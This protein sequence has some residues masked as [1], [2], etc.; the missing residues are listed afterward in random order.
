MQKLILCFALPLAVASLASAQ[1]VLYQLEGGDVQAQFGQA[2]ASAGD[3]N[4]DGFDDVVVG[5]PGAMTSVGVA[6]GVVRVFSGADGSLLRTFEGESPGDGF[7]GSVLGL[8]DLNNDGHAEVGLTA[9]GFDGATGQVQ[10]YNGLDGGLMFRLNGRTNNDF[11]GASLALVGDLNGDLVADFAVGS[12]GFDPGGPNFGLIEVYSGSN[13]ALLLSIDGDPDDSLGSAVDGVGDV[14]GDGI[15][16]ILAGLPSFSGAAPFG[17]AV[18]VFSGFNGEVIHSVPGNLT[19]GVSNLGHRVAGLGDVTGDG[20]PDFAAGNFSAMPP[21]FPANLGEVTIYDGA[22]GVL[23]QSILG[24][25]EQDRFGFSLASVGDLDGDGT[26]DWMAGAPSG[27][28]LFPETGEAR[29]YSGASGLEWITLQ[30]QEFGEGF[31][32]SLAGDMDVNADGNPDLIVG[33]NL[34]SGSAW[35]EGRAD[36]YLGGTSN[37]ASFTYC[38]TGVNS[39]GRIAKLRAFGSQSAAANDFTLQVYDAPSEQFSFFLVSLGQDQINNPG[40]SQG[41]LCL[42]GGQAIGRFFGQI[43]QTQAGQYHA[44]L[45]IH[46]IPIPPTFDRVAMSGETWYFQSWY[47]DLGGTSNFS[48]GLGVV[49]Q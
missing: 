14:D 29:V 13:A 26:P 38:T 18:R 2:V 8:G 3:V 19:Y 11:F 39:S 20:V 47:R 10:V 25:N 4:N 30:G 37:L 36:V 48:T 44:Q 1:A 15:P 49:F 5:S 6:A 33:A 35:Q 9:T 43:G 12:L 45:D 32:H 34:W 28:T 46:A 16:D 41:N 31:G 21:G 17:G 24:R 7:G 27:S 22:T 40:G 23:L 42:G